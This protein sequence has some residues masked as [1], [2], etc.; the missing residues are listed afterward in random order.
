MIT[1][2]CP[3]IVS[4]LSRFGSGRKW[5]LRDACLFHFR[6]SPQISHVLLFFEMSIGPPRHCHN[7]SLL[8]QLPSAHRH[9]LCK[10]LL[11]ACPETCG[12]RAEPDSTLTKVFCAEGFS[13]FLSPCSHSCHYCVLQTW[14]IHP[15]VLEK[16]WAGIT[17]VLELMVN[18]WANQWAKF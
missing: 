10:F 7:P 9:N 15:C 2:C 6:R 3:C 16:N 4:S 13:S 17:S 12:G 14:S 1:W 11:A 5:E 8:Q 18:V